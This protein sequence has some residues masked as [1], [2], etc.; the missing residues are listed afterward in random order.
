M[1]MPL[2]WSSQKS[3]VM[4]AILP[5]RNVPLEKRKKGWSVTAWHIWYPNNNGS[6]RFVPGGSYLLGE[7]GKILEKIPGH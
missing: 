6:S 7:D 5:A 4:A 3:G 1:Q 2:R